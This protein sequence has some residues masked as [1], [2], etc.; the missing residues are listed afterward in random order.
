MTL[1]HVYNILLFRWSAKTSGAT[2]VGDKHIAQDCWRYP[3]Q[4]PGIEKPPG[5]M[6]WLVCRGLCRGDQT[7]KKYSQ[8]RLYFLSILLFLGTNDSLTIHPYCARSAHKR[9]GVVGETVGFPTPY[10][11]FPVLSAVQTRHK[12]RG[13]LIRTPCL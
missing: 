1:I 12:H 7:N 6:P 3:G 8:C 5:L 2:S 11:G 13:R 10:L 4:S 9:E